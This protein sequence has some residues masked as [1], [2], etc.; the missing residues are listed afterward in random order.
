MRSCPAAVAF[1]PP[2]TLVTVWPINPRSP[3]PNPH[4]SIPGSGLGPVGV[5]QRQRDTLDWGSL[6]FTT[7]PQPSI[8]LVRIGLCDPPPP[9]PT[10]LSANMVR[11]S[12]G[13]LVTWVAK[14]EQ[15]ALLFS[16]SDIL[17]RKGLN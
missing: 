5:M 2:A 8:H 11:P 16:G 17:S 6:S 14:E 9:P 13:L 10:P 3:A 15:D 12:A 4:R 1:S 7:P